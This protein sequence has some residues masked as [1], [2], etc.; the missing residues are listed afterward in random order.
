MNEN[1][2]FFFEDITKPSLDFKKIKTWLSSLIKAY[3]YELIEI[4]YILC[5]DKYLLDVN[6]EYLNH[7]YYTDIITFDNSEKQNTIEGDIFVSLER[8]KDNAKEHK[9]EFDKEIIRVH[10]H[11]VLHLLGYRDKTA[12]EIIEMRNMEEKA[13]KDYIN[14]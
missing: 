2:N 8:V 5:S 1:I 14:I 3:N 11:G 13:I 10:A 12:E 7:D 9:E 4:N 6:Q